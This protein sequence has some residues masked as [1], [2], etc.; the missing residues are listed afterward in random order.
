LVKQLDILDSRI[1]ALLKTDSRMPYTEMA[2][3][4]RISE[5]AVRQRVK[6]LVESG[7]IKRFTIETSENSPTALV[8]ISASA[9]VPVP[10]VASDIS[11]LKGV[12]SVSEMAGQFDVSVVVTGSDVASVNECIDAIRGLEGVHSTNTYFVLR[13][14]K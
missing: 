6:G 1:L 8:L 11:S 4:L 7:V 5:G 14:W 10:K 2:K 3:T 12:D 13:K 9:K